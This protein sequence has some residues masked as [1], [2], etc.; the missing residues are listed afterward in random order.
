MA[1]FHDIIGQE[2]IKEHLQNAISAKKISHAYII[3]GE[4]SSGKEF[5]ARVFAQV[6]PTDFSEEE[7]TDL[8][9]DSSH[10]LIIK[11]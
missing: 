5:I 3:N 1:T 2:Q 4:K 8:S 9:S 7:R 6:P 11:K 10:S